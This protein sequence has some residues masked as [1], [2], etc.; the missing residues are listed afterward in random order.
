MLSDWN[1]KTHSHICIYKHSYTYK[2]NSQNLN[3][4]C[5]KLILSTLSFVFLGLKLRRAFLWPPS[6]RSHP[7]W[8]TMPTCVRRRPEETQWG[9]GIIRSS[10][11]SPVNGPTSH[12]GERKWKTHRIWGHIKGKCSLFRSH[13]TE[14]RER[15]EEKILL[16][17][18]TYKYSS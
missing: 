17:I 18:H 8:V 16:S 10:L 13:N 11:R 4:P 6:C 15:L 3:K 1:T 14:E 7:L 12:G 5:L 2:S 9:P